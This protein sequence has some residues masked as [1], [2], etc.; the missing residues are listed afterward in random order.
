M[1]LVHPEFMKKAS[2]AAAWI[3]IVGLGV[4]NQRLHSSL[5]DENV[6][7][8]LVVLAPSPYPPPHRAHRQTLARAATILFLFF[9]IYAYLTP[10][11]TVQFF[12]E[13]LIFLIIVLFF[14][15]RAQHE[16]DHLQG[17]VYIDHLSKPEREKVRGR[18][19]GRKVRLV[20]NA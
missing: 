19:G 6:A 1:V 13:V 4:H 2:E 15:R 16:Y 20:G 3:M 14:V 11:L 7:V 9:P 18:E 10:P 8:V 17:T 12:Y 5:A